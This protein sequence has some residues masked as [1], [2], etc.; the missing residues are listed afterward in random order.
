[1]SAGSPSYVE[2]ERLGGLIWATVRYDDGANTDA[3][4]GP[5]EVLSFRS[6]R[7]LG[8]WLRGLLCSRREM[9]QVVI[10]ADDPPIERAVDEA[11]QDALASRGAAWDGE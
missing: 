1:M 5:R 3:I 9:L 2:V 7:V 11:R 4:E 6:E 8:R 10:Y